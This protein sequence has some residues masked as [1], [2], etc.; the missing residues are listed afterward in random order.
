MSMSIGWKPLTEYPYGIQ[1]AAV[2]YVGNK[3]IA[4]GGFCSGILDPK[5]PW[6]RELYL[7]KKNKYPRGFKNNVYMYDLDNIERK[8]EELPNFPGI[9]RQ[10]HRTVAINNTIYVWGGF[11]YVPQTITPETLDQTKWSKKRNMRTYHDGYKLELKQDGSFQWSKLPDLPDPISGFIM[12]TFQN[13]IYICTG[14]S[15]LSEGNS[16]PIV[17]INSIS[18]GNILYRINTHDLD[19]GWEK[20]SEFPGTLRMNASS[21][22]YKDELY[23]IGGI[24]PEANWSYN[25]CKKDIERFYSVLDNWKY[26]FKENKWYRQPEN[27][28]YNSNF[29]SHQYNT[30]KNYLVLIGGAYFSK[31]I[32]NGKKIKS[33]NK[34]TFKNNNNRYFLDTIILFNLET[35]KF[36]EMS[37]NLKLFAK[38]N[39]T[40]Y[41]IKDDKIYM[42][43]GEAT[44]FK[45]NNI[46]YGSHLDLFMEGTITM[47]IDT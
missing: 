43:G 18:I 17:E 3:I 27:P 12:S 9:G 8:W 21:T 20:I 16:Q 41:A 30:F 5:L 11:S 39:G 23:I 29:C 1:E 47:K 36:E 35:N 37:D 32:V 45:Y 33:E 14:S 25:H 42:L 46:I 2:T 34:Y 7:K 24:Y 26:N 13:Y 4:I 38:I 40:N 15:I 19:K 22:I 6:L 28:Y 31:S 44:S 10:G